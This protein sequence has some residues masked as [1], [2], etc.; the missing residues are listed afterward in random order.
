MISAQ[1]LFKTGLILLRM[2]LLMNRNNQIK[3]LPVSYEGWKSFLRYIAGVYF[4][5][6]V[7][8]TE[9]IPQS[10]SVLIV[11]NHSSFLDPPLLGLASSRPVRFLAMQSVMDYPV[12]GRLAAWT[13][14]FGI[15]LHKSFDVSAYRNVKKVFSAGEVLGLFPEGTRNNGKKF[16]AFHSGAG[17]YYLRFKPVVI[18]VYIHGTASALGTSHYLPRPLPVHIRF[19]PSPELAGH[20]SAEAVVRAIRKSILDMKQEAT[21]QVKYQFADADSG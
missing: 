7:S 8:G 10:G 18:P 1:N 14:S 19:A 4:K 13:G 16:L 15:D 12:S 3:P 11:A 21:E 2:I 20:N 17:F 6:K 5:L 9:F